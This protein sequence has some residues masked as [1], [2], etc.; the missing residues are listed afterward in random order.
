MVLAP[1]SM[2]E[3]GQ[4]VCMNLL[5][6][7]P[8]FS[9]TEGDPRR[10]KNLQQIQYSN[11]QMR[12]RLFLNV[13]TNMHTKSYNPKI[14]QYLYEDQPKSNKEPNHMVYDAEVYL[15]YPEGRTGAVGTSC[16]SWKSGAPF[17][18]PSLVSGTL[19]NG[20]ILGAGGVAGAEQGC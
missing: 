1:I 15:R 16:S 11:D 18:L 4:N 17:D 19:V 5:Y 7:V 13:S 20:A 3:N 14:G 8:S 12:E 9:S 2:H 10:L 6:S